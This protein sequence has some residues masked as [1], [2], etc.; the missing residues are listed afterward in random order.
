MAR[1]RRAG[2]RHAGRRLQRGAFRRISEKGDS[3]RAGSLV[4]GLRP[5]PNGARQL[6]KAPRLGRAFQA[7]KTRKPRRRFMGQQEGMGSR[8]AR[9]GVDRHGALHWPPA[10][11]RRACSAAP[12]RKRRRNRAGDPTAPCS[13][14]RSPR[15]GGHLASCCHCGFVACP[16]KCHVVD[17]TPLDRQRHG[18]RSGIRGISFRLYLKA[19][20]A[21]GST[22]RSA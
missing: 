21:N 2:G 1:L 10:A 20:S 6:C 3:I 12:P 19:L 16:I 18:R 22:A 9:Q 15:R 11:A 5:S 4:L 13:P 14:T 8:D 7:R 17:G